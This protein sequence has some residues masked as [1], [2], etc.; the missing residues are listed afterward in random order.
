MRELSRRNNHNSQS[1]I[2]DEIQKDIKE[3]QRKDILKRWWQKMDPSLT[4]KVTTVDYYNQLDRECGGE[5]SRAMAD[6][7][8]ERMDMDQDKRISYAEF[9]SAILKG[10]KRVVDKI[11][12]YKERQYKVNGDIE[13]VTQKK[14]EAVRK[15]KTNPFG[16]MVGS[17]LKI[18]MH[19]IC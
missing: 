6:D 17:F 11:I 8:L 1:Q 13:F 5:Y 9:Q 14:N 12:Y 7:L 2:D 15:E 16:I 3:Q 18:T 10:E 19:K 4:K